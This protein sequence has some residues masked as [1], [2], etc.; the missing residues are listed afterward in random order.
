MLSH[1]PFRKV[2]PRVASRSDILVLLNRYDQQ[3]FQQKHCI[4]TA[5]AGEW[6]EIGNAE[7]DDMLNTR[8]PIFVRPGGFSISEFKGGTVAM[9]LIT[10]N[11]IVDE[12]WF[13]GFCDLQV[14]NSPEMLREAIVACETNRHFRQLRHQNSVA[15]LVAENPLCF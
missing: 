9:V 2:F 8:P 5:Y 10:L 11:V 12:R 6:F 14:S 15:H 7:Y 13:M 1:P 3:S 4:D